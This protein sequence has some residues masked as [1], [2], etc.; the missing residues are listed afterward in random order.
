MGRLE[1]DLVVN[2]VLS[3]YTVTPGFED[4]A[5]HRIG[6]MAQWARIVVVTATVAA[7][8]V[9][10]QLITRGLPIVGGTLLGLSSWYGIG[11][12]RTF[13]QRL[14]LMPNEFRR[15][16]GTVIATRTATKEGR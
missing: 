16:D 3:Q 6:A 11:A 14:P 5:D 8:F 12:L 15:A 13:R 1:S 10:F 4:E 9:A 7:V 2:A